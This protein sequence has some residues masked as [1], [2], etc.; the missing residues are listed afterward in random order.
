MPRPTTAF[1]DL[2]NLKSN[3][4]ALQGLLPKDVLFC[5][6]VKANAYGHGVISVSQALEEMGV[7]D[8]GVVTVEE[9]V[10]LRESGV[11]TQILTFCSLDRDSIKDIVQHKLTPVIGQ[12]EDLKL[13]MDTVSLEIDIHVKLNTG[14]NRQGIDVEEVETTKLLLSRAKNVRV[15]AIATHLINGEDAGLEEGITE[16]Q[17]SLFH[18]LRDNYFSDVPFHYLNSSA[19]LLISQ[20]GAGSRPGIAMYGVYPPTHKKIDVDLKPVMSCHSK[21]VRIRKIKSGE[22]V[23]YGPTW[24]AERDSVVGLIPMGYADGLPRVLSNKLS[25]IF[26]DKIVPAIGTI[27]MDYFLVD[28]TDACDPFPTLGEE[29]ILFGESK[30]KSIGVHEIAKLAGTIPYEILTKIGSR[31]PRVVKR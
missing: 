29:V 31:I 18:S 23:S 5:P 25:V 4:N 20:R 7:K 3:V 12:N 22:S 28:L 9:G 17:L 13:I 14:M 2:L 19:T 1:I 8:L 21:L 24:R 16:K 15:R 6:M 11:S 26:R 10:E 27:C 30:D